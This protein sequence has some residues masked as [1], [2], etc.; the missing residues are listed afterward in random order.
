MEI[1]VIKMDEL[2]GEKRSETLTL[3][4]DACAQW[5]FFWVENHGINDDI[6]DKI[7]EL[8]NKHYEE[9]MEKNFYSSEIAKTLGP[10]KVASNVDWECSFMYH[11]QPK[12]NIHDIP[13]LLRTTVPEYAEEVV[14]LAEQLAEVMSENLGLDKD[15][16]KKAFCKPSV[17]IKVAK[18]PRCSHP[19]VV[20]GLRGHTDAGGIILLFQDD[21]V[22]GLE[23]MKDGKRI[24]I[25]PTQGNRIFINLGDQI[26]VISN[27]IYKSI[28]HQVLPNQN[29]SRL[30]I[31][32][33]Y[34]PGD[35]A[36]I[37]PAPKLT[38]PSQYRFQDYLNFYSTTKFTDKVSRFQNTKMVFK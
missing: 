31:A 15:Y 33:F 36:I 10:D 27:G 23:F 19:E 9:N 11:H 38:Y 25:P 13:E 6:M 29:G 21:Q 3:L 35:D 14:K 32:T 28:C 4:H 24:S 17:G 12:S 20:M 37:F 34:N 2:Y 22:P 30:S 1:P 5:G 18:Y 26:E 7:K 16:L 8:V